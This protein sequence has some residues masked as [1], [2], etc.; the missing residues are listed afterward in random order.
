MGRVVQFYQLYKPL[1]FKI[2]AELNLSSQKTGARRATRKPT[3]RVDL[4][5]MV[6]LAFLLIT[7]FMLTTSLTKPR[8]MP[9]VMPAGGEPQPVSAK[10]TMTIVLGKNNRMVWYLGLAEKPLIAPKVAGYG[11]EIREAI[12]ETGKQV[13]ETSGKKLIVLIKPSSHSVYENLVN[14]LDELNITSVPT[15]AIS[16]INSP[17]IDLLKKNGIY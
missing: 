17:D 12:I 16:A 2:M 3:P 1:N 13:F 6:D 10:N 15:Y 8:A 7:F 14:V 11:R 9:V 4:T 5:A